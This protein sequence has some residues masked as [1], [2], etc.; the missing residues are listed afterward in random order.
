MIEFLSLNILIFSPLLAA[1]IVASPL[2]GT[3]PIYIRRFTKT[4]LSFHFLYSLLFLFFFYF[5]V[6]TYYN[7]LNIFGDEWLNKLGINAAFG[8]DALTILLIILSSLVFLLASV[9][10]KTVIRS[11]HKM[12]YTL[13]L[14]LLSTVMG[15]F[16]AKD[17]F[18]FLIFWQ[19]EL[20]PLYFIISQWGNGDC[21]STAM[22]YLLYMFSGSIILMIAMIGLYFYGY[23]SNQT[24]TSSIDFLKVYSS[25]NICPLFL[26]EIMFWCFFIGITIKLPLIPF[27]TVLP[28]VQSDSPA[29]LNMI[30]TI[31]T[32]TAAYGLIR[33]NLELFPEIFIKYSPV[34]MMLAVI[35][36]IWAA[37]SA[38]K[39]NDIKKIITYSSISYIGLFLLGLS[40]LNKTG[41]D[42][43]L[44]L[45]ISYIL[46]FTALY[47]I[48]SLIQ[49]AVKTK[50]LFEIS[51]IGNYM[52]KL[53]FLSSIVIFAF[54]GIPLTTGFTG[55]F[56]CITGAFVS[57]IPNNNN[58][59]ILALIA[60]LFFIISSAVILRLYHRVFFGQQNTNKKFYDISGHRTMIVAVICFC[61]ILF[62]FMPDILMSI[63]NGISNMLIDNLRV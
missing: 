25:D 53:M 62:G 2:F 5:G 20:I 37:L 55:T 47:Y 7:E 36:I 50:S 1:V 45:I 26:Q 16:C 35:N 33:F 24:L 48:V 4:F 51:G 14:L 30:S 42:G 58:S 32:S 19:A 52:P 15:I 39:Q 38:Y 12:Y 44:F 49:Q 13:I 60:L 3:N 28:D 54:T 43:A 22:K 23:Y 10:S 17:M 6:E 56:L 29:P 59:K 41:I 9:A 34:I 40:S 46:V 8:T 31:L 61:I 57:D 27:H 18:V 63:Y 11:K 21:K